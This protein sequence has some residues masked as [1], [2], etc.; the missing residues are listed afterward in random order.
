MTAYM[1]VESST[2]SGAGEQF[3]NKQQLIS[4]CDRGVSRREEI[5]F[6]MIPGR[7]D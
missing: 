4:S 1:L 2:H 6:P 5:Q 3:T 7:H